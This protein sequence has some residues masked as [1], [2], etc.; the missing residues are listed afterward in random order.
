MTEL[1]KIDRGPHPPPTGGGAAYSGDA[2][3]PTEVW[4]PYGTA[5]HKLMAWD[6]NGQ[7]WDEGVWGGEPEL[8]KMWLL[9]DIMMRAGVG[10]ATYTRAGSVTRTNDQGGTDTITANNPPYDWI[11]GPSGDSRYCYRVDVG[12]KL[13]VP[14]SRNIRRSQG[15]VSMWV[16]PTTIDATDRAYL[17]TVNM[18]LWTPVGS[19]LLR[20]SVLNVDGGLADASYSIAGWTANS[21]HHIIASWSTANGRV[22]LYTDGELRSTVALGSRVQQWDDVAVVGNFADGTLPAPGYIVDFR[23]WPLEATDDLAANLFAIKA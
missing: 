23:I 19:G 2:P 20:A 18:T 15:C 10:V 17:H 21:W 7:G 13:M 5:S 8:L 9:E 12:S 11:E 3:R 14:T 16:R 22:R 6:A 1:S 4:D